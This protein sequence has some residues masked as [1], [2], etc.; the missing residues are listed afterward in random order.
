HKLIVMSATYRQTSR[1][2]PELLASDDQNRFYG[3]GPRFRMEAE[4]I[5]DNV[6]AASGLLSLK[7]GGPPVKP[8]QPT[9]IW[10]VT[11][12]V[13]NTYKVS[14]GEDAHRRGIY[15]VWRRSAPYP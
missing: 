3:R 6:L 15:T 8:F 7:R 11:G 12:L 1:L 2:T 10:N 4:M 5:R 13:D 9:G 14:E